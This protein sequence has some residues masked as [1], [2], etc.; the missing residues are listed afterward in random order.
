MKSTRH[1]ETLFCCSCRRA[2]C[3]CG[4][5]QAFARRR[6]S[7]LRVGDELVEADGCLQTVTGVRSVGGGGE[8]EV[9]ISSFGPSRV[10]PI[11]CR[12]SRVFSVAVTRL[13]VAS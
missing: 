6:A 4:S 5:A 3:S 10:G 8:L 11:V 1:S 12:G 2:S 9:T 13:A 7:S